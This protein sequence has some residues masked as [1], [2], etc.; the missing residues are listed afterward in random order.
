MIEIRYF[1]C[2]C[3]VWDGVKNDKPH[4]RAY[5]ATQILTKK[6]FNYEKIKWYEELFFIGKQK[7]EKFT[8]DSR[9]R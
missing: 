9:R 3:T 8:V 7:T 4:V 2:K 6:L 1:A 5:M